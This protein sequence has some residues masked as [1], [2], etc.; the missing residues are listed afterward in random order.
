MGVASSAWAEAIAYEGFDYTAGSGL[1]G[2]A[3]GFGWDLQPDHP[4]FSI[5]VAGWDSLQAAIFSDVIQ[6][7]SLTYADSLG[8]MLET[9]GGKLLNTG[10]GGTSQGGRFLAERRSTGSTWMSYLSQRIGPTAPDGTYIRG[11]NLALFEIFDVDGQ[12]KPSATERLNIGPENSSNSWQNPETSMPEDRFQLRNPDVLFG[13]L[14]T[15]LPA[16]DQP[17]TP[18]NN[19]ASAGAAVNRYRDVFTEASTHEVNLFVMRIDHVADGADNIYFWLNPDLNSTPSDD[20][21][22]GRYLDAHIQTAAAAAMIADPYAQ[23]SGGSG[24][25][26]FDRIRFFAGNADAVGPAELLVDE[27]RLGE[28]FADVTPFIAAPPTGVAGDYN[29]DDVVNAADYTVWRD[30]LG[31]NLALPNSDPA[32]MDGVVTSAEYDYWVSRFGATS[33]GAS[34]GVGSVPEPA[35]LLL[36]A[37]GMI[38]MALVRRR[39]A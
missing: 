13:I 17:P 1:S 33:G 35:T 15:N 27:I 2:L 24:E 18:N 20:N 29:E 11:A 37:I 31:Q 3:G 14:N 12:L 36:V 32:D 22:S 9:N 21:V 39:A 4:N 25:Q 19:T 28:T 38:G 26:T 5:D 6:A 23:N 10:A 7:D 16:E 8:N 30:L 34:L